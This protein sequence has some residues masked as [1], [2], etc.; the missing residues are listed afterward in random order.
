MHV[1]QSVHRTQSSLIAYALPFKFNNQCEEFHSS[2]QWQ[3]AEMRKQMKFVT[4]KWQY[5]KTRDIT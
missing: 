1:K 2:P 4:A 5:D 3:N